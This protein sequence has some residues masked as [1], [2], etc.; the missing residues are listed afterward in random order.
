MP[1]TA[2]LAALMLMA[3][4]AAN[5]QQQRT[6][7]VKVRMACQKDYYAHCQGSVVQHACLRQYW[8]NLS[9]GCQAALREFASPAPDATAGDGG[10]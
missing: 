1:K 3:A 5:A 6:P 8:V 10:N 7:A 2:L 4:T 9:K